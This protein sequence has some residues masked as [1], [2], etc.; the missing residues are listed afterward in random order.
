MSQCCQKL[1]MLAF[2]AILKP[3]MGILIRGTHRILVEEVLSFN[4]MGIVS[5]FV[6][7]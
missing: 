6:K 1:P 4:L 5:K 7:N 3:F 2:I